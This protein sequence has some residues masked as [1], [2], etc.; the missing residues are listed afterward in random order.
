MSNK[1]LLAARDD[2]G[3][4]A[5]IPK[6]KPEHNPLGSTCQLHLRR[7]C[8]TCAHFQVPLRPE[9][10][11]HHTERHDTAPCTAFEVTARRLKSAKH[12]RRWTR[13]GAGQE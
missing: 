13:K 2:T 4:S 5:L 1:F 7:I 9:R 8:G 10:D 3:Y 12:C 6:R 11:G